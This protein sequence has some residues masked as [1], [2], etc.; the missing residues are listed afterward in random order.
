MVAGFVVIGEG[1]HALA[2]FAFDDLAEL[3]VV[4]RGEFVSGR[5]RVLPGLLELRELLFVA[6]HRLVALSNVGGISLFNFRKR[7][8]FAGIIAGAD[9]V[10][11]LECHVLEHVCQAG[12]AHGILH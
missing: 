10:R 8:F 7:N 5:N 11:S 2:A 12:L 1:V 4:S 3:I 9:G 6:V